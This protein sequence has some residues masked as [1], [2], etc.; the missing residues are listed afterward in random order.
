MKIINLLIFSGW[1]FESGEM[2]NYFKEKGIIKL[3]AKNSKIKAAVAERAIR[4]LKTRFYSLFS[5][6]YFLN[7]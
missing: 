1:E 4:T 5:T 6:N 3:A 7:F 2:K